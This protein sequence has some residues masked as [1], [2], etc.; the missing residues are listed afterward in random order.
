MIFV[1]KPFL[2][3]LEYPQ[4]CRV[5]LKP[6]A[7]TA[8]FLYM[9]YP[10]GICSL[11]DIFRS[12][13]WWLLRSLKGNQPSPLSPLSPCADIAVLARFIVCSQRARAVVL[14]MSWRKSRRGSCTVALPA[15]LLSASYRP[16]Q[17]VPV[18]APTGVEWGY[19]GGAE[20]PLI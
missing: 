6:S 17:T 18:R 15:A 12:A 16:L 5:T 1:F 11:S 8:T 3:P 2:S 10:S 14:F 20:I 9:S 13:S 7:N 4:S 19:T